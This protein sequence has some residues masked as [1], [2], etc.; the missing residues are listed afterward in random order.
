[1]FRRAIEAGAEQIQAPTAMFYGANSASVRDP[2]GHVWVLLTWREDLAP[3]EME[4]PSQRSTGWDARRPSAQ[5]RRVLG[6]IDR[7]AATLGPF[8]LL[9]LITLFL[10]LFAALLV[11]FE[12]RGSWHGSESIIGRRFWRDF[13]HGAAFGASADGAG[14]GDLASGRSSR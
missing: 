2:F 5:L 11:L 9:L 12:I 6:W 3:A 4:T 14:A 7:N 1:V 8:L 10:R 13:P